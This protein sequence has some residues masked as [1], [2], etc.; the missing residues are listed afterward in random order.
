MCAQHVAAG[1]VQLEPEVHEQDLLKR[2]RRL[3]AAGWTLRR[4]AAAAMNAEGLLTRR[5]TAWRFQYVTAVL[6]GGVLAAVA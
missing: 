1:G 2:M 5:G 3:Q 4:I 6:R